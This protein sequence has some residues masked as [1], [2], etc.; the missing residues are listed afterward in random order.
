MRPLK[1]PLNNNLPSVLYHGTCLGYLCHQIRKYG[2]YRHEGKRNDIYLGTLF[3]QA[4]PYAIRRANYYEDNPVVLAI[5]SDKC[6][7]QIT[8]CGTFQTRALNMG[9]FAVS[10]VSDLGVIPKE[11]AKFSHAVR[12]RM[13]YLAERVQ[14]VDKD[15]LKNEAHDLL[16]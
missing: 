7:Y 11:D 13:K 6:D 2:E 16:C 10:D 1:S 4:F 8:G 12:V 9:S 14:K 3:L 15:I 5:H